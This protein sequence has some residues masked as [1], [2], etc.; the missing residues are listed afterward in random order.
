ME[1]WEEVAAKLD[2]DYAEAVETHRDSAHL[3][4]EEKKA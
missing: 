1:G 2:A 3:T 4:T